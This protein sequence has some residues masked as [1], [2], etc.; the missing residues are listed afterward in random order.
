MSVVGVVGYDL[1]YRLNDSPVQCARVWDAKRFVESLR[2]QAK[3]AD[4]PYE[5]E[6]CTREHYLAEKA[7]EGRS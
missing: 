5:V 4:E 3:K 7:A 2:E 1:Y 6:L